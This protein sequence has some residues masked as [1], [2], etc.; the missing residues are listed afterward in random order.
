MKLTACPYCY[1]SPAVICCALCGDRRVVPEEL[2]EEYSQLKDRSIENKL[3]L[4]KK[5]E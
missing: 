1:G 4:R 5:Y 2:A 3:R